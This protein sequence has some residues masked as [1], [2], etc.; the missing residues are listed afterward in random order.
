M[1]Y[2]VSLLVNV[3]SCPHNSNTVFGSPR[4]FSQC[5]R[6]SFVARPSFPQKGGRKVEQPAS[7][8]DLMSFDHFIL[9]QMTNGN[10]ENRQKR[11]CF[12]SNHFTAHTPHPGESNLSSNQN[13]R[14]VSLF[15]RAQSVKN[16]ET[17]QL[18]GKTNGQP[19]L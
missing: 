16:K 6:L 9:C 1:R 2:V 19:R 13:Q 10:R 11:Q 15:P 3:L 12:P 5:I 17:N 7:K 4:N 14:R 18:S 8:N